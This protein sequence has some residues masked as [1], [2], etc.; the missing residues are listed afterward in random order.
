M[1]S[2]PGD[3]GIFHSPL[4]ISSTNSNLSVR[5]PSR[6]ISRDRLGII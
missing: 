2:M 1:I 5:L 4:S 3:K 6:Q